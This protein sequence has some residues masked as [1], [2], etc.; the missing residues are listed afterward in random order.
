MSGS[1]AASAPRRLFIALWPTPAVRRA[2]ARVQAAWAWP[3]GVRHEA[4][5]RLHLTLHFLGPTDPARLPALRVL[6]DAIDA[7]DCA[8]PLVLDRATVW[9]SGIAALE[10]ASPP[11][12]LAVLHSRIGDG[13]AA[14]GLPVER[15]PFRPHVTLARRARGAQA[16]AAFA[17]VAW[18]TGRAVLVESLPGP[19]PRYRVLG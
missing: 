3:A 6:L 18:T 1:A 17:P 14:L 15:R 11:A 2:L 9:R 16:P 4:T 10:P 7:P 8:E 13:L 5:A 19:P 12:V